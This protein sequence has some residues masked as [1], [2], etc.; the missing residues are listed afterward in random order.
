MLADSE[1]SAAERAFTGSMLAGSERSTAAPSPSFKASHALPRRFHLP[2]A[3][4]L[5]PQCSLPS[6]PR[7]RPNT[8]FTPPFRAISTSSA[9][10][11]PPTPPHG[12]SPPPHPSSSSQFFNPAVLHD[13]WSNPHP[14]DPASKGEPAVELTAE[15]LD[16]ESQLL[17]SR[18]FSS[19]SAHGSINSGTL[20]SDEHP[21]GV[22]TTQF[23]LLRRAHAH[24]T[25]SFESLESQ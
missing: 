20:R 18:L 4:A 19:G 16:S 9:S 17:N 11:S 23:G 3:P 6:S 14:T 7:S 24:L 12:R 8:S 22:P 25:T 13:A 10:T 15:M 1:R 2:A 5:A 21:T